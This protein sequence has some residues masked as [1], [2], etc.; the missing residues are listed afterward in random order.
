MT[1]GWIATLRHSSLARLAARFSLGVSLLLIV[2]LAALYLIVGRLLEERA[3]QLV[4][5]DMA[6]YSDVYA[7]RL[8][9]GLRE[10]V[11]RRAAGP[12]QEGAALLFGREG[13]LLA[14]KPLAAMPEVTSRSGRF[15][16][17]AGERFLGEVR[18]LRGGFRLFVMR[19]LAGDRALLARFGRVLVLFGLV[20]AIAGLAAGYAL[21]RA[22]LDRVAEL[23]TV[24]KRVE[25]GD[26]S[27]RY[28]KSVRQDE[29]AA[30]GA[31]LN[32]MLDRL[33]ASVGGLKEV[34]DRVA[35]EMRTPLAHLRTGLDA[36]R[37]KTQG[38]QRVELSELV[39][40]ADD[41]IAVFSALLDIAT[42]EAAASDPS[43]L[44]P[45]AIDEVV[46]DVVELYE[47][48]AEERNVAISVTA[49]AAGWIMGDR[50]LILRMLANI[51][52]NA[53]KFSPEGGTVA[54]STERKGD[55]LD[56]VVRD[57]GPGIAAGFA[58][59]AFDRFSRGADA[60]DKPGHGLGLALVRA[61]AIRHG[62]KVA[63]ANADPGLV[64]TIR[65]KACAEPA[66]QG[67]TG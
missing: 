18:E 20:V 19:D 34:S 8:L 14:G 11:D 57:S 2:I 44:A 1:A 41:L 63:H 23:D 48:V 46:D 53:V 51:V 3:G 49:R 37:R 21:G 17:G 64:V 13:E 4:E 45:V 6:S 55:M 43:G 25:N 16:F 52:D 7:Q 5:A 31:S 28:P 66:A 61:I 58:A 59:R 30:I 22:A 27:A 67:F 47:A 29:F 15:R 12:G 36:L 10:A 42:T 26:L 9:P 62:L 33:E 54:I 39:A 56:I 24:L 50:P 38:E 60:Q 32:R 40:E 35:H 65:G